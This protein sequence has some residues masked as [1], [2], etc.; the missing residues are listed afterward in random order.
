VD[1]LLADPGQGPRYLI[2]ITD[3]L[4][5]TCAVPDPQEGEP[6]ALA[7]ARRAFESGIETFVVGISSDIA[8]EHLQQMANIAQGAPI[9]AIWGE[10]PEAVQPIQADEQHE[11]LAGQIKGVLGDV[12]SCTIIVSPD[13]DEQG[14]VSVDGSELT[15]DVDYQVERNA[16]SLLGEACQQVL[17]DARILE[18][19]LSCKEP[20]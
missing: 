17:D 8:P 1:L 10:D 16:L 2:L 9:D 3:G 6:E 18:V 13:T 12:R 20:G 4:P 11:I 15:V 14:S 19:R 7:A 5:D